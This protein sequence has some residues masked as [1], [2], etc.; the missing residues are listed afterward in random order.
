[1]FLVGFE[2]SWLS[3]PF[4]K[5]RF[6]L[7]SAEDLRM[8]QQSGLRE[9]WIDTAQGC[10]VLSLKAPAPRAAPVVKRK[11]KQAPPAALGMAEE[12]KNARRVCDAARTSIVNMFVQARLGRAVD[13]EVCRATVDDIVASVE[14]H[15]GALISLSR[16]KLEDDYTFM[17]SVAVCALM[18]ALARTMGLPAPAVREA[19]LAGLVHDIGKAHIPIEILNKP[20]SLDPAEFDT[21]KRHPEHGYHALSKGEVSAQVREACLFHHERMDGRGY[22]EARHGQDI[23]LLARMTAVCDVYDAVTSQRSYKSAWDPADALSR[24]ISW[25]GHF[26]PKIL[27]SFIEV[28][29]IYPIGSLVRLK[30]GLLA[31]VVEQNKQ[32]YTKPMVKAFY[33]SVARRTVP[34]ALL[35][36]ASDDDA[37]IGPEE[38]AGWPAALI[39]SL[40]SGAPAGAASA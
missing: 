30:S 23:P 20:G 10:D 29:G 18:V 4:W 12:L 1:M 31:V 9:C 39:E 22:P 36:L 27:A 38:R 34:V 19:G 13:Q 26:D 2:G 33:D 14:R 3:N 6:L 7:D 28:V 16:L 15:P 32:H 35:D 5:S 40:W 24:M 25:Q 11:S 8:A 17:H 37:I 21:V